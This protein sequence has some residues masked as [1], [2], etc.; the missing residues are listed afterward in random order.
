MILALCLWLETS[1]LSYPSKL[2]EIFG[3]IVLCPDS[4][5]ECLG[6][7]FCFFFTRWLNL[8]GPFFGQDIQVN[9]NV[10]RM[11]RTKR[12]WLGI[13]LEVEQVKPQAIIALADM[14]LHSYDIRKPKKR[15]CLVDEYGG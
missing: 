9:L 12:K 10:L 3:I 14:I 15:N 6:E 11:A 2:E 13:T 1:D 8:L 5:K 4:P 7:M